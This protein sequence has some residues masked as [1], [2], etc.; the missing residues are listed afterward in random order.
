MHK[1]F[2]ALLSWVFARY[3][4]EKPWNEHMAQY[5]TPKNLNFWYYFGSL[6]ILVLVIQIVTG[7][8]LTMFYK[9]DAELA[10]AS[11]EF[12]MRDVE[13]G[14][15]IRYMHTVGASAFFIIIYLHMFKALLY[16]SYKEPRELL[17]INGV[18]I[19]LVLM[20]IA[21]TGYM[22][23]WGQMSYWGA[24][25][26]VNLFQ[27]IPIIG[28]DLVIWIRGD[29]LISDATLT[30]F[31][32]LHIVALPLVL[33][34]LVFMHIVALHAVGSNNPDGVE[35]KEKK[36]KTGKPLDGIPFHPYFTVKDLVGFGVFL[37]AFFAV[38]FFVPDG[39][40]YF[41]EKPNYEPANPLITPDHI[42]PLWFF[43]AWYTVLRAVPDPFLGVVA[44]FG[45]VLILFLLPW[46]DR[47]PIKSIRYRSD[48]HKFNIAVFA[49]TFLVLSYLGT[50]P[51]E[52]FLGEMGLRFSLVYF[53]FF[54]VIWFHS[55]PRSRVFS[56]AAFVLLVGLYTIY[57]Y[58]RLETRE[59]QLIMMSWLIP[60]GYLAL[61]LLGPLFTRL[62]EEKP[63]PD[64]VTS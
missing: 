49:F 17:W 46:L 38:I 4:V 62:N 50:Q 21:F 53:L 43:T 31:Y 5:Y 13:W 29:F 12:I 32:A 42:A 35:I 34:L 26:I 60:T 22:L 10:F 9:P 19:Y 57:D 41:L 23:P 7:I 18:L 6:S 1:A 30:R 40:G 64:R 58:L 47:N 33:F 59:V 55:Q 52:P 51:P 20:G 16:G 63:V 44:M 8:W 11:I 27:T 15:F 61:C 24:Q 25:V 54:F 2:S 36:D 39:G 28:P 37:I 48:L 45:A 14:W 3:P 56:Y